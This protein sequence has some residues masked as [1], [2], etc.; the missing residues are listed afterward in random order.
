M[1]INKNKFFGI[2]FILAC[3]LFGYF[4]F[5]KA[6]YFSIIVSSYNYARYLPQT[7]DSILKSSYQNFEL[8]IVNDGS[9]DNTSDILKRFKNHPKITIIEQENQGLSLARNNAMKI[10]K[11]KYFWFVDAD[12]WIDRDALKILHNKTKDKTIDIVSFYTGA[13]NQEGTFIGVGGY[14]RIPKKIDTN[15]KKIF[16]VRDLSISELFAYPVTSGKQIY[17]RAFVEE[18]NISFPARTLFE[19]DVFF[20]HNVFSNAKISGVPKVLYYKRAH[21]QA[22]TA[23][24][25]KHY[26]S[27]LRICVELYERNTKNIE[28]K[29]KAQRLAL[30]YL[31]GIKPRWNYVSEERRYK[32]YPDLEKM[33]NYIDEKSQTDPFWQEVKVWYDEFFNSEETQKY[34]QK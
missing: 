22:I 21:H 27:Y 15:P 6:P 5:I 11:G 2:S 23:D 24:K 10:A 18:K 31:H 25:A 34:K 8:I 14:D 7:I 30:G 19:D 26:D 20:F 17:R 1:S 32:F 3:L 28:Q 9:T 29:E 12:D 13:V 16:T 4:Y 33:K